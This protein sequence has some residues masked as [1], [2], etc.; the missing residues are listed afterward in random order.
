M[1][2]TPIF[3][4]S[5]T[6]KRENRSLDRKPDLFYW[7]PAVLFV[8]LP[9]QQTGQRALRLH[10]S[11]VSPAFPHALHKCKYGLFIYKKMIF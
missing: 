7:Y 8:A 10:S 4:P 1:T 9:T 3:C 6:K 11:H 2:L 5:N